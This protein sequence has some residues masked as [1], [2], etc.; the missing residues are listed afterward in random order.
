MKS[1]STCTSE[2]SL[3]SKSAAWGSKGHIMFPSGCASSLPICYPYGY[4]IIK[5][6]KEAAIAACK[7]N[8]RFT[9][10]PRDRQN[11]SPIFKEA[12]AIHP[13]EIMKHLMSQCW[14]K[15]LFQQRNWTVSNADASCCH[16]HPWGSREKRWLLGWGTFHSTAGEFRPGLSP[17]KQKPLRGTARK[18]GSIL[19]QSHT[20][21]EL[22]TPLLRRGAF[23]LDQK[24]FAD[25]T[26]SHNLFP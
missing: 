12:T 1:I 24:W 2:G 11:F 23:T 4:R 6:I 8:L 18:S 26:A 15:K 13:S 25:S 19:R 14:L 3:L 7:W 20:H 17:N 16:Q 10:S 21:T 5:Y 9:A 22:Y